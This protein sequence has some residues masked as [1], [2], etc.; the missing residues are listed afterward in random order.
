[1]D[2]VSVLPR[3]DSAGLPVACVA[4]LPH[5]GGR[6]HATESPTRNYR[7]ELSMKQIAVFVSLVLLVCVCA[8]SSTVSAQDSAATPASVEGA[9][10]V[11]SFEVATT[12]ETKFGFIRT[13]IA[14]GGAYS[15]SAGS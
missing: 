4:L 5:S 3:H 1:A 10:S 13:T 14:P 15:L 8:R 9:V 2:D 6:S 11:I 12:A 7:T